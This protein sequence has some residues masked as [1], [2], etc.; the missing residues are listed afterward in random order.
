VTGR[1][2]DHRISGHSTRVRNKFRIRKATFAAAMTAQPTSKN[3]QDH[4]FVSVRSGKN[5]WR[6]LHRGARVAGAIGVMVLLG[7]GLWLW[8]SSSQRSATVQHVTA[9][10]W[11]AILA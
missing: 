10:R 3:G 1:T 8:V 9:A 7:V 6:G 4:A 5:A 11:S 2:R